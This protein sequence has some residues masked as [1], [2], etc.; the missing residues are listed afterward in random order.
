MNSK[1]HGI[2]LAHCQ[3]PNCAVVFFASEQG[4]Q[5]ETQFATYHTVRE[6]DG[7]FELASGSPLT[8]DNLKKIAAMTSAGLRHKAEILP[9]HVLAVT[10]DLLVWW[11]PADQQLMHFDVSM[12]GDAEHRKRLQGVS[13]KVPVPALVFAL[14]RGKQRG[15]AYCGISVFALADNKRPDAST[16]LFRAPL[17]NTNEEGSVCWG[18]GVK[19]KGS[20]VADIAAWQALFFS[21]VFTHYNGSSPIRGAD[22]YVLIAYLLESQATE[23][24]ALRLKP[25][26][27]S[28][29]HALDT[30]GGEH[31]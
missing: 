22:C 24:P 30:M 1:V 28:L 25:L 17:L 10:D 19:P 7:K 29:Q 9:E 14:K 12:G 16:K 20:G 5:S 15:H 26:N 13:G 31:G 8:G 23:F 4:A 2:A 18:S 27:Y 21:S 3:V 6:T 11:M